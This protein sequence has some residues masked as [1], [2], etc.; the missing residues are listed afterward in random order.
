MFNEYLSQN[1]LKRSVVDPD[2]DPVGSA[3]FG[4]IRIRIVMEKTGPERIR[5][6]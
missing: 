4:W 5:V 6:A 1:T 3:S 2:P